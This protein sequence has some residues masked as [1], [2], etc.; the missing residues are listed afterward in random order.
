MELH[1]NAPPPIVLQLFLEV[2]AINTLSLLLQT[3]GFTV[4]LCYIFDRLVIVQ[5]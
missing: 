2:L 4:K 1:K 5:R 3:V